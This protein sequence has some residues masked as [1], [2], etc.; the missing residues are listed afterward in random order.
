M[1]PFLE[2]EIERADGEQHRVVGLADARRSVGV[3]DRLQSLLPRLGNV[4]GQSQAVDLGMVGFDVGPEGADEF[5]GQ[6]T[7]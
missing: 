5:H 7:K 6:A 4:L 1:G 2:V 3:E